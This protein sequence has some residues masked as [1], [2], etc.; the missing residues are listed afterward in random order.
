M[1]ITKISITKTVQD[2][3]WRMNYKLNTNTTTEFFL[4]KFKIKNK[5]VNVHEHKEVKQNILHI[6]CV[7]KSQGI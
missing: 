4:I 6:C 7:D 1:L 3:E 5:V 2:S